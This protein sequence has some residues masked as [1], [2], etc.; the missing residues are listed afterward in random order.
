MI[1]IRKFLS[2]FPVNTYYQISIVL[3]FI[4]NSVTCSKGEFLC[5][6]PVNG[7]PAVCDL[8]WL[9][10]QDKVQRPH[11]ALLSFPCLVPPT[12]SLLIFYLPYTNTWYLPFE[13]IWILFGYLCVYLF[14]LC[15]FYIYKR[16]KANQGIYQIQ[17]IFLT[18]L[19]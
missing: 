9:N 17:R 19:S 6:W 3:C 16:F 8:L 14:F 18:T 2:S 7:L 10:S 11:T 12:I 1:L 5:G 15:M 4:L 13:T